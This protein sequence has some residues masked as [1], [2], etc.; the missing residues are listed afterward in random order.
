MFRF[1][2]RDSSE[3]QKMAPRS[4]MEISAYVY[5][6]IDVRYRCGRKNHQPRKKVFC[7]PLPAPVS[8]KKKTKK[9]QLSHPNR[10]GIVL[11][12]EKRADWRLKR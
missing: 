8:R 11:W 10:G 3:P 5:V 6:Y 4:T 1:D 7:L 9:K 12:S 2:V